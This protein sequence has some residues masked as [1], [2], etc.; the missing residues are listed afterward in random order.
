MTAAWPLESFDLGRTYIHLEDGPA[1]V[2]VPVAE[3]FWQ[4][5]DQHTE[6]LDGRLMTAFR[7]NST[8]DWPHWEMHPAGDE[9]VCLTS[10]AL[11]LVLDDGTAERIVE[12]RD[13]ATCVIPRGVWHRAIVR[14]PSRAVF[15]TRAAGTQTRPL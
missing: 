14:E 9:I 6:L 13:G 2:R 11:D 8:A 10:G 5:I 4:T 15:I 3:N 1:A 12:L 7:F